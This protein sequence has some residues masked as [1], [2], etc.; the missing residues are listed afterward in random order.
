MKL[1]ILL[2]FS[3]PH[4]AFSQ[5]VIG[6]YEYTDHSAM[7]TYRIQL[8]DSSRFIKSSALMLGHGPFLEKGYYTQYY[9]TLTLQFEPYNRPKPFIKV[10][11]RSPLEIQNQRETKPPETISLWIS[12]FK[13]Q[14][15]SLHAIASVADLISRGSVV[16]TITTDERGRLHYFSADN[17]IDQLSMRSLGYDAVDVSLDSLRGFN[18]HIEV[19]LSQESQNDYRETSG[20]AKYLITA[21]GKYLQFIG[22]EGSLG[23]RYTRTNEK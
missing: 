18:S 8:L 7:A 5:T 6:S 13:A 19:Y 11:S 21:D 23:R 9:D 15:S 22:E 14:E 17:T 16:A 12:T 4:I 3:F 1:A 20:R 2:L 10:I